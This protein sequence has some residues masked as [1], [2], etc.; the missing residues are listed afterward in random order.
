MNKQELADI[1]AFIDLEIYTTRIGKPNYLMETLE[2]NGFSDDFID[3]IQENI[4]KI[5]NMVTDRLD[6]KYFIENQEEYLRQKY[7]THPV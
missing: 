5:L 2:K 7:N 3:F 1:H 6:A 4:N